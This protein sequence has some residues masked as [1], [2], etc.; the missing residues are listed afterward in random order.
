MAKV[1][2]TVDCPYCDN[3]TNVRVKVLED[4]DTK[5]VTC[6]G[7]QKDFLIRWHAKVTVDIR[8]GKIDDDMQPMAKDKPPMRHVFHHA[9]PDTGMFNPFD[10]LPDANSEED[11]GRMAGLIMEASENRRGGMTLGS[12][13][14]DQSGPLNRQTVTVRQSMDDIED[15]HERSRV[16]NLH[17]TLGRSGAHSDGEYRKRLWRS[18]LDRGI[19]VVEAYQSMEDMAGSTTAVGAGSDPAVPTSRSS[20]PFA[21]QW[22]RKALLDDGAED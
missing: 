1:Y 13:Q 14:L 22:T 20:N 15:L 9:F 21:A 2:A 12:I 17:T 16:E 10:S 5:T 7:C 8:A 4:T 19:A 3:P 11:S 6:Y 18:M